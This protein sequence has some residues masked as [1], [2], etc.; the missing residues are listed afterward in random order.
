MCEDW[1]W[2]NSV[3]TL[4]KI[5]AHRG[6]GKGPFENTLEAVRKAI[7]LGVDGIEIDVHGSSDGEIV[8][9]H[10]SVVEEKTNGRGA[11]AELT[12]EE[13]QELTLTSGYKIPT[14]KELLTLVATSAE[15]MINIE[16]K[17]KNIEGYVL[18]VIQE[19]A[20][21]NSV[22]ISS[23]KHSVLQEVR[24]RDANIPTLLIFKR[25]LDAA[26]KISKQLGCSGLAPR[27]Q[28]ISHAFVKKCHQVGLLVY[29][30]AVNE[31]E[32]MQKTLTWNVDGIITDFPEKLWKLVNKPI[33]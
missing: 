25:P 28:L 16:I 15:L 5:I 13:L 14:L 4:V 18:D 26:I 22:V 11:V 23:Y 12:L 19:S 31:I 8:V 2:K 6:Y 24:A 1:T 10:D 3:I 29:P 20:L 33:K 32:D 30:W 9:F 27:F 7:W 21:K 17:P